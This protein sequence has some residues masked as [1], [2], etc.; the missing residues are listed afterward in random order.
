MSLIAP[1]RSRGSHY[2]LWEGLLVGAI[3]FTPRN[4]LR[5]RLKDPVRSCNPP[6]VVVRSRATYHELWWGALLSLL[7][8]M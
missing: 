3:D 1:S 8:K 5:Q 2:W 6:Q 4:W 7:P